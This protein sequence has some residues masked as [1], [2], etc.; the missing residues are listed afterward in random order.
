[1]LRCAAQEIARQLC[2]A[3]GCTFAR[4][5]SVDENMGFLRAMLRE[6][7]RYVRPDPALPFTHVPTM[8]FLSNPRLC[9]CA[10][11]CGG[12][13]VN[14]AEDWLQSKHMLGQ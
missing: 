8:G 14:Q 5:A 9:T 7:H 10:S 13:R 11:S 12:L 2:A 3:F 1:M 4:G 6:L